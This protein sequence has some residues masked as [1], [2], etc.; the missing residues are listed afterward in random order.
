MAYL[1]IP[2][3]PLDNV[4]GRGASEQSRYKFKGIQI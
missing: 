2:S 1:N 4:K 3:R